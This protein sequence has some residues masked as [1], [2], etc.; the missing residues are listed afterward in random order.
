MSSHIDVYNL[1]GPPETPAIDPMTL[2]SPHQLIAGELLLEY[3]VRNKEGYDFARLKGYAGTGKSFLLSRVL[4]S[5]GGKGIGISAPTHKAVKVIKEQSESNSFTFGTIHSLFGLT[6]SVSAKGIVS[7]KPVWPPKPSKIDS[8]HLLVV[9]EASM[10]D[11]ALLTQI[12]EYL[13]RDKVN[14]KVIFC[15]DPLQAPPVGEKES[16][17]FTDK[18]L[19]EYKVLNLELSEPMRQSIDNPILSYATSIRSNIRVNKDYKEFIG[20]TGEIGIEAIN[21]ETF[22]STVLPMF[23][24]RFDENQDFIKILA[25]TNAQVN[26][27][28]D[29][30]R[31]YRLKTDLP[32]KLV[33]GEYLVADKPIIQKGQIRGIN[34]NTSEEME[35]VALKK[36]TI[37]ISW[38][39]YHSTEKSEELNT[40]CTREEK[41]FN[42][43][44]CSVKLMRDGYPVFA[45]IDVLHESEEAE[46]DKLLA[47][48]KTTAVTSAQN[49]AAWVEF[50]QFQSN[51]AAIK[52]NY[53]L[54]VHKSQG[55]S[56]EN[57]GIIL[58]DIDRNPNTEEKNKL[59]Y[60]AVTRAKK[61]LFIIT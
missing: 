53:A 25:W 27:I 26:V 41:E 8:L 18:V 51:F 60:V 7:Y 32:D 9:D 2:L 42:I 56:Y 35:V 24:E 30:I 36:T 20:T 52:Y 58:L 39:L 40:S 29:L 49:K 38:K 23:D 46:Y 59:K 61:K 54:T 37:K 22:H 31:K 45:T 1:F 3:L 4:E 50:Y 17:V 19:E 11:L 33:V 10:L 57:C 6:Q 12:L 21:T 5:Y 44:K 13:K 43:Y 28:N 15:G 14:L 47:E 55:S 16:H 48:L 34:I